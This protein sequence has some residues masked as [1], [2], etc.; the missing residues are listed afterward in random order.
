LF[1]CDATPTVATAAQALDNG[2]DTSVVAGGSET[3]GTT[4]T[5]GTASGGTTSDAGT[6]ETGGTASGGTM[7][8]GGTTASGGTAASGG[9]SSAVTAVSVSSFGLISE[10]KIDPPSTDGNNE[11]I[12][13]RGDPGTSWSGYWL[14]IIEG[15]V[16]STLGRVDKVIDLSTASV[17]SNGLTLLIA[18]DGAVTPVDSA[19]SVFVTSALVRGGLENGTGFIGIYSGTPVPTVGAD[20]DSNDD[21]VLEIPSGAVSHD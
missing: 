5:G 8:S 19:A 11:Y 16:E 7:T 4:E 15:D 18:A 13:L 3:S 17:G 9:S 1:G 20:W 21:G 14:V 6:T 2:G 12:E 10:L